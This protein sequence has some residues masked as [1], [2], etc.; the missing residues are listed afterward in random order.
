MQNPRRVEQGQGP[1]VSSAGLGT[2]Q[3]RHRVEL[4][5]AY[6]PKA[7]I[8]VVRLRRWTRVL[9]PARTFAIATL[10]A[11][12]AVCAPNAPISSPPPT[13]DISFRA[14]RVTIEGPLSTLTL[15][16]SVE[17]AVHRYRLTADKLTLQRTPGG[18]FVQ[19]P[20]LVAFCPCAESPVTVA[21]TE[22][23]VAPPTDL[24]IKNAVVRAAGVPVFYT[25][26]L[27][28][29]SPN[30]LGVLSPHFGWRASEGMWIGSGIH[31]PLRRAEQSNPWVLDVNA[32][33]YLRGGWDLGGQLTTSRASTQVRWDRFNSSF[34]EVDSHGS[35]VLPHG[36]FDWSADL[37]R[38]PRARIGFV[39][40]EAATQQSDR[41][42]S[43]FIFSD[44]NVLGGVGLRM[45]AWRA[46]AIDSVGLM[47]PQMRIGAG[48]SLGGIGHVESVTSIASWPTSNQNSSMLMVHGGDISMDARPSVFVGRL[49]AH[50]RFA[51]VSMQTE[52]LRAALAGGEARLSL[53]LVK[54]WDSPSVHL[55]HWVEPFT[56][57]T[58]SSGL[59]NFD[60]LTAGNSKIGILQFGLLNIVGRP[61]SD[62]AFSVELRTGLVSIKG[63]QT[64][65]SAFRSRASGKWLGI[66]SDIVWEEHR[67][68]VSSSRLRIG[69]PGTADLRLRI[70]GRTG[71]ESG[72]ARWFMDEGWVSR[73]SPWLAR[74]GW[75][76]IAESTVAPTDWLAVNGGMGGDLNAQTLLYDF[77]GIAYRHPCGCLAISTMVSERLGRS[78]W[79]AWGVVDLMPQ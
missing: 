6:R 57:V 54:N 34:V 35:A 67:N 43:E 61:G 74:G 39:S 18:V 11:T 79:D 38:G 32:G 16:D 63:E 40:P 41:A 25:P 13:H 78:G 29:R 49:S 17:V 7:T 75:T 76:S 71:K 52:N 5:L 53:P 73:Y 20:G 33:G 12:L 50:E 19:G 14:G 47:G 65:A 1:L 60:G 64:A 30:R 48:G 68:W 23:T 70:E 72:A 62:S 44:A 66:G 26:I 15:C 22:A 9:A 69:N 59:N 56:Q 51:Y 37:L 10:I 21:F 8:I 45:D 28:L 58:A 4:D 55:S 36:A 2:L 77:A 24:L 3:R 46:T 27:W 31:V 42:R